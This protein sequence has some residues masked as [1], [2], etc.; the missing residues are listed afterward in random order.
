MDELRQ[1][2]PARHQNKIGAGGS[3]T[4]ILLENGEVYACGSGA[5]GRLGTGTTENHL[6]PVPMQLPHPALAVSAGG[7]H[8][9]ILLETGEVYACGSGIYGQL[10]TGTT[11]LQIHPI[12]MQLP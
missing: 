5:S 7:T 8:T 10:G 11:E 9:V 1:F 6:L 4:V 3:H 12:R 2:Y